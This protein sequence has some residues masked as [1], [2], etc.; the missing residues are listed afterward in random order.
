MNELRSHAVD[1]YV[2]VYV[3]E[4]QEASLKYSVAWVHVFVYEGED[5]GRARRISPYGLRCYGRTHRGHALRK[6]TVTAARCD[7]EFSPDV[8]HE[9]LEGY[10][11][12][13]HGYS[14]DEVVHSGGVFIPIRDGDFYLFD[15]DAFLFD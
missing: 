11:G 13:N 15:V 6:E 14:E 3:G 4:H 12:K 1:G 7:I 5:R 8:L 2:L 9:Y 10:L